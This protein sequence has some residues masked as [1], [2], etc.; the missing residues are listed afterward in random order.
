MALLAQ[1]LTQHNTTHNTIHRF[2][3]TSDNL[4]HT[5]QVP[6]QTLEVK[7]SS[8]PHALPLPPSQIL[9]MDLDTKILSKFSGATYSSATKLTAAIGLRDLIP[10]AILDDKI[11]EPCGYSLNAIV[12]VSRSTL[13]F[14]CHWFTVRDEFLFS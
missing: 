13:V 6:D 3:Y 12:K 5:L 1:H 11:F 14:V 7:D 10:G 9:M 4:E 2:L 8:Q